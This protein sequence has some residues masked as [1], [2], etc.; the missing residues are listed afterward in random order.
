V[1]S[2]AGLFTW[3]QLVFWLRLFDSTAMY[4]SLIIRTIKDISYFMI[5]MVLIMCGFATAF[6]ML[7]MNRVYKGMEE[8]D[9]LYPINLGESV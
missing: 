4:V 2:C 7:Q 9:L 5:V 1:G 8:E 6:Y 3:F